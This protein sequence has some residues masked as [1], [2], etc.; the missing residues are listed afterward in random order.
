[1][2]SAQGPATGQVALAIKSQRTGPTTAN[3]LAGEGDQ[4]SFIPF[5][6][7]PCPPQ[8]L[9]VLNLHG[10]SCPCEGEGEYLVSF[11]S[12][13]SGRA[14]ECLHIFSQPVSTPTPIPM[15]WAFSPVS[16]E[17]EQSVGAIP[18][19]RL[20]GCSPLPFTSCGLGQIREIL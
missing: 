12:L 20:P 15:T 3:Y 14:A 4:V 16:L 7:G 11:F 2:K 9:T 18:G 1:M 19:V 6:I 13:R 10:Y 5:P 8:H 17:L